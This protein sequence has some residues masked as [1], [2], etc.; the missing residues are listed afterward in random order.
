MLRFFV[1]LL[2][3]ANGAYFA[4][5]QGHLAIIGMAPAVQ[6][7][8]QRQQ[9][10]IKPEAIRLLSPTEAKRVEALAAAPSPKPAECLQTAL[11]SDAQAAAVRNVI[12]LLPANA[13]TLSSATEPARWI[14]Y[15]GKYANAEVLAKKKSELRVLGINAESLKNATLEPGLSL[16]AYGT[17][18][19]ANEAISQLARRGVRTGRVLQELP[20]R[21]GQ[22]LKLP[23]VD[24]TLRLQL[25]PFK[26]LLGTNALFACK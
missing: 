22:I 6:T 19:Q 13:W 3:L 18:Q 5:T 21:S 17:Q 12:T 7:E 9:A 14:I 8:P 15:M 25:D 23:A 2:L 1:L 10:Q 26:A 16:G 11:L 4:W 20:E 24:D